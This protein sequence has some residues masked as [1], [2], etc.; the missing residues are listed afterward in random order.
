[1]S[2]LTPLAL[3]V[4]G[5]VAAVALVVAGYH[6]TPVIGPQARLDRAAGVIAAKNDALRASADA[7]RRAAYDLRVRDQR[8]VDLAE[9]ESGDAADASAFWKGQCRHAFDAGYAARRCD[10][11]DP[12]GVRDLRSL[13]SAGA[14]RAGS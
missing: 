12:D 7:L 5:A 2:F 13:Q 14:F 6:F 9:R 3:R 1:M 11:A 4:G 10:G 8:I